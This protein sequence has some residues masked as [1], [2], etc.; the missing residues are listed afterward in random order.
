MIHKHANPLKIF[1]DFF[2]H[3]KVFLQIILFWATNR[4]TFLDRKEKVF[5]HR[6]SL[7]LH[8]HDNFENY[9]EHFHQALR[10]IYVY[11]T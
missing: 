6:P 2:S 10:T 5:N 4:K 11:N 9:C 3:L 8:I 1:I 7:R